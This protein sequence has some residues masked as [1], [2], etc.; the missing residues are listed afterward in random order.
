[1]AE[2]P[3]KDV[4]PCFDKLDSNTVENACKS[5]RAGYLQVHVTI[6][7]ILPPIASALFVAQHHCSIAGRGLFEYATNSSNRISRRR[8]TRP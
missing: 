1:M 8:R 7:V 3:Q 6:A 2:L 4:H 5:Y